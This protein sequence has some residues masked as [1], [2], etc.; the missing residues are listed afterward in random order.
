MNDY[1][2]LEIIESSIKS[3]NQEVLIFVL[4]QVEYNEH[5]LQSGKQTYHFGT[6]GEKFVFDSISEIGQEITE[7]AHSESI[8]SLDMADFSIFIDNKDEFAEKNY[9]HKSV[10]FPSDSKEKQSKKSER[11]FSKEKPGCYH[12]FL[13]YL[14]KVIERNE[15][16]ELGLKRIKEKYFIGVS[17]IKVNIQGESH[18]AMVETYKIDDKYFANRADCGC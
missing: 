10:D 2:V 6:I 16:R 13:K 14:P 1:R 4:A 11:N 3:T 17:V 18:K 9:I 8:I 5:R 15:L 12:E 7:A